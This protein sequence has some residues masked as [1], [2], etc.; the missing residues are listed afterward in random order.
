[1]DYLELARCRERVAA[2]LRRALADANAAVFRPEH[3]AAAGAQPPCMPA[4][5]CCCLWP[6][7][8]CQGRDG[9]LLCA[10]CTPCMHVYL[11]GEHAEGLL[12]FGVRRMHC[13]HSALHACPP[14]PLAARGL[15]AGVPGLLRQVLKQQPACAGAPEEQVFGVIGSTLMQAEP[16]EGRWGSC[17]T[18]QNVNQHFNLFFK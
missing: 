11:P 4:L 15:S 5:W 1:M 18:C 14:P 13:T 12:H 16:E 17:C 2:Q 7:T 9:S 8:G 10:E 6:D 3:A